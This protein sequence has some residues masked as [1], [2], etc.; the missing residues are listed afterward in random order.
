MN[1]NAVF[2]Y[3]KAWKALNTMLEEGR[4]Y[5]GFERNCVF[6]NLGSSSGTKEPLFANISGASGLDVIDDG[7]SIA[8]V[9]WDFDGKLDFWISNRTAPRLRLQHNR[10]LFPNSFV[11]L[12][13]NG[14]T[15]NR[16]AIGARVELTLVNRG[17]EPRKVIETRKLHKT[18]RAG[19]GFLAQSSSWVHFG[20]PAGFEVAGMS[21]R[22][23]ERDAALESI[24][25]V[26]GNHFFRVKQGSG[27]AEKWQAPEISLAELPPQPAGKRPSETV[28]IV[29]A[30]PLP[31]PECSYLDLA[32]RK[33]VLSKTKQLTLINL[34]ATWCAPCVNEMTGWARKEEHLDKLGIRILAL[35]V[36]KPNE[37]VGRRAKIV[38]P[39]LKRLKFPFEAGL[40]GPEFL[41]V[42]EVAGRAQLDKYEAFPIPSS[43]LLDAS[44]RI[45]II[46]KG[47]IEVEQLAADVTL[48]NADARTRHEAAA[49][50]P[51][52]WIDGPRP[53]APTGMIDKFLSS[54]MPEAARK[55]LDQFTVPGAE[56]ENS[57][58][59]ESYFL[60]ASE[61]RLR[62]KHTES[63][64]AYAHGLS[65]DPGKF[66]ARQDLAILLFRMRKYAEAIPHLQTLVAEQPHIVNTRKML[67]L[68]LFQ[69]D[70]PANAIEQ[71]QFLVK[72]DPGDD[73]ARLWLGRS[74]ALDKKTVEAAVQFREALRLDP[75]SSMAASELAWLLAT[76]SDA[77]FR[78]PKEALELATRAAED[79]RFRQPAI[80]DI[81]AAAQAANGDY[82]SAVKTLDKAILLSQAPKNLIIRN[83]LQLRRKLYKSN[84]PY[85]GGR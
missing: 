82:A 11:A 5:S 37:T 80:L 83:Q 17:S 16:D 3:R 72:V 28:R 56:G 32:G 9:D 51:G 49:H 38:K 25:G 55:Y 52:V 44:G 68:S 41:H 71:F 70:R 64:Q 29:M 78:D 4:S 31:L 34:W 26:A 21:V 40:A 65:L 61:L 39:F 45:A 63:L 8:V 7:R 66:R 22:W 85:R 27:K 20:I 62:K 47:P 48:L 75:N 58:L 23:P 50:F 33:I 42:L 57:D 2:A 60:V 13:L 30:S 53:P 73:A 81:L 67:G 35:S 10:S 84:H 74:L 18:V 19:E 15:C 46:Y 69:S 6:L 12:K 79:T 24:D 54:G 36:D 1:S 76:H 14:K 59:A 43:L 77:Q